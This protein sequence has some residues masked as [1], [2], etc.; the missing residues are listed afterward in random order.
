MIRYLTLVLLVAATGAFVVLAGSGCS[1]GRHESTREVVH[2]ALMGE[3][4]MERA[5]SCSADAASRKK[6]TMIYVLGST[7]ELLQFH[8][9]TAAALYKEG[10]ADRIFILS[11]PGITE[12][13]PEF[14]RNLTNDEWSIRELGRH[15]VPAGHVEAV[16]VPS[17]FF[18]TFGEARRISRFARGR[19]YKRLVLVSSPH[20]AKRAHAAFSHFSGG[21]LEV[22]VYVSDDPVSLL[23]LVAEYGKYI[24]YRRVLIPWTSPASNDPRNAPA[25]TGPGPNQS[26]A[27]NRSGPDLRCGIAWGPTQVL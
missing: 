21:G 9:R 13:S 20:H 11:R 3:L 18:G 26:K 4:S 8:F 7:Q 19:G 16:P 2:R 27:R 10:V 22:Q 25:S 5:L 6:E 15:G 24:W 12:Y 23:S 1:R 17:G 14:R